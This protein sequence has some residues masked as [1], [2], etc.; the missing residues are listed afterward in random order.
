[1]LFALLIIIIPGSFALSDVDAND[2]IA[3][4]ASDIVSISDDDS[5]LMASDYYFNSSSDDDGAGSKEDPYNK[6]TLKRITSDSIIH[7]ANGEYNLTNGKKLDNVAIIGEDADKTILRYAGIS[8]GKFS[9]YNYV[10]LKNITIIGFQFDL[11]GAD[12]TASNVIFKNCVAPEEKTSSSLIV[13]VA[14]NSYGGAIRAYSNDYYYPKVLIDNCTFLNNTAEYGGA[15][16]IKDGVLEINDTLFIDNHASIY[17]GSLVGLYGSLITLRDVEFLNSKAMQYDGGAIYLLFSSLTGNAVVIDNSSAAKFGGAI[18]SLNSNLKL[19]C[20]NASNNFAGYDGGAIYQMYNAVS[21][22]DSNLINNTARYGGAIF[23]DDVELNLINN[24][25]EDNLANISGNAV[26]SLLPQS[27]INQ[28][29]SYIRNKTDHDEDFCECMELNLNIGTGNYTIYINNATFDGE[30]P[31]RYSLVDENGVTPIRDQGDGGNCWA[32]GAIAALESAILKASGESLDL[33]EGNMKNVIE[34]FCDYGWNGETNG[35]GRDEMSIAYLVSWLGP[36]YE[37]MDEYDDY[38]MLSPIFDSFM[39]VQN[40]IYLK[41][42]SFTDNDAIKQAIIKYG[43]VA[44]GIY[45]DGYS[46]SESKNSYYFS[47]SADYSNHEVVIVGWDDNYLRSNFNNKPA[48]NGAWIAKNSWNT[49]WGDDGY[50]Y[51]SYYDSMF[52]E[53]GNP[54]ACY[55]FVFND[56]ER[57]DKNYQYDIIGETSYMSTNKNT[58]WVENIFES[59]DTEILAAVSTYFRKTMD[60]ELFIYVNDQLQLTKNGTSVPG[61][62]TINLGTY[63][64]LSSGDKF[65]VV[66]KLTCDDN[67][68]EFAVSEGSTANKITYAPGVSFFS[69]DGVGWADLYDFTRRMGGHLFKSQVACIKAFTIL[70]ESNP[71][72]ELNVSTTLDVANIEVF[73]R[74]LDYDVVSI[75]NV[76]FNIGGVNYTVELNNSRVVISHIF[77]NIGSYDVKAFYNNITDNILVNISQLNVSITSD[78]IV[79]GSDVSI[80]FQTSHDL[81]TALDVIVND[82][83]YLINLV[84]NKATLSLSDLD[85]GHYDVHATFK[86]SAYVGETS[87][88]FNIAS[89]ELNASSLL[90]V[91]TVEVFVRDLDYDVLNPGNV[92]IDIGGVNYTVG[93]NDYKASLSHLF[94]DLGSYEVNAYYKGIE[95]SVLVNISQLKVNITSDI[96]ISRN[97]AIIGFITSHDLNTSLNVLINNQS[98]SVK[99]DHGNATLYLNNLAFDHYD[100]HAT[101][102]DDA[103]LGEADFA[104]D[105][106][107]TESVIIASDLSIYYN[108]ENYY[109]IQLIDAFG[110]PIVNRQVEFIIENKTL[111]AVS[112]YYGMVSTIIKLDEIGNHT[113]DIVFRG[114]DSYFNSSAQVNVE[115][116]SSIIFLESDY[117]LNSM[118]YVIFLDKNG[119]YLQNK[120]VN[121]NIDNLDYMLVTDSMGRLSFAL[122]INTGSHNITVTNLENGEILSQEINIVKRIM[123]NK[124]LKIYYLSTTPYK[125]RVYGDNAKPVGAGVKVTVVINKKTYS[126]STDDNGYASFKIS[127]SPKTY[128]ITA[129]YKGYKV[130]NKIVVKPVLTA[131]NIYKKK[132]KKIKFQAKLVNTKGKAVKGKKITFKFKGKKYKAKTNSKGIATLTLKNLKVGK[133]SITTKYGKSTIKNTIKI[134][135]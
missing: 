122:N 17:G 20:L 119:N 116:K 60:Y 8:F 91:A 63:V 127:L 115:V 34:L 18:T 61:Y 54:Q 33:S 55:A 108:Y 9:S 21:L 114:D 48:G 30:L 100:V 32:F 109:T 83:T 129:T 95:G 79:L 4:E 19:T 13:N 27:T 3:V 2:T 76:T 45:F 80:N 29:N 113:M 120:R 23:V 102:E 103:Y 59:T 43:A 98:Y 69:E 50:F 28:N 40:I 24:N 84:Q 14:P 56:S 35:G 62:M 16:Y 126:V 105:I 123:E 22:T 81:D 135:K 66:F 134:K 85:F 90:D 10:T 26:Y 82:K 67:N 78:V 1:M 65:K 121:F 57:Y 75:G 58:I 77:D 112:D 111:T 86:D 31:S 44:T 128:K 49:D 92:V 5:K 25:F 47:G 130:S 117:L 72:M 99:L 11:D 93:L 6:L 70:H 94:D 39:H 101:F 73:V 97:N 88:A 131:K 46:Y 51:V 68:A 74:D 7:L 118:Y 107:I 89:I 42:D 124:D 37:S 38:N 104:F 133:Y 64:P 52:A 96:T 12:L 36:I 132:A 106:N 15:I 71:V 53:V 41:R 87:S 110:N 125:F